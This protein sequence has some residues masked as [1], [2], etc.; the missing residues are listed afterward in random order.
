M[1]FVRAV[2]EYH[3]DTDGN[4]VP[5]CE[6]HNA[7]LAPDEVLDADGDVLG[8]LDPLSPVVYLLERLSD[9]LGVEDQVLDIETRE[10]AIDCTN[11]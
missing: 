4:P 1:L 5:G 9:L 6:G 7:R 3:H 10:W 8:H 2:A 11:D